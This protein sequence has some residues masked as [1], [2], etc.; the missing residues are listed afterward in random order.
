MD[1]S[2]WAFTVYNNELIAGGNF[3]TAGGVSANYI[4]RWNG[5]RWAPLGSGMNDAVRDLTVYNGELIAGGRFTTAGGVSAS[6]IAR[7]DGT[8]WAPLGS[9]MG[10]GQRYDHVEALTVYNGELIAGGWFTTAGGNA[11]D[12]WARWFCAEPA[13]D[14]DFDGDQDVDGDDFAHFVQC[15][16]GPGG[17]LAPDCD[18]GDFDG[19]GDV[20]LADTAS[21]QRAFTGPP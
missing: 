15:F 6:R 18:P 13:R 20:D 21:F 8:S 14:A 19:D 3:T 5:T 7:W 1:D 9:G 4:A 17:Q 12:F 16:T 2:V 10:G 11:S